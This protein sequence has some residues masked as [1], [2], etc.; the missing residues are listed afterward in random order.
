HFAYE[1]LPIL[2]QTSIDL[3]GGGD[4]TKLRLREWR[5]RAWERNT[6]AAIPMD[7]ASL[8][9]EVHG[10]ALA[11]QPAASSQPTDGCT[12]DGAD[13]DGDDEITDTIEQLKRKR[14]KLLNAYKRD[15]GVTSDRAIYGCA[16]K[17]GKHSCHK[18]Q[19]YKWKNGYLSANSQTARSLEEFLSSR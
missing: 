3:F 2:E 4:K 9:P 8:E 11:F 14:A 15:T 7:S 6:T 18:P 1:T 5:A 16:G 19:F 12:E 13:A 17:R 10:T